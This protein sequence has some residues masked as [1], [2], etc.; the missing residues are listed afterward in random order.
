MRAV[1]RAK[2]SEIPQKQQSRRAGRHYLLL[3]T[4]SPLEKGSE[5]LR[6]E[7]MKP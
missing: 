1:F 7:G 6:N 4:L 3:D 2:A 5:M